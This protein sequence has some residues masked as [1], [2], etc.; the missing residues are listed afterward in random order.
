[1]RGARGEPDRPLVDGERGARGQHALRRR[2]SQ[3]GADRPRAGRADRDRLQRRARALSSARGEGIGTRAVHLRVRGRDD[4]RLVARRSA[5]LVD[6]RRHHRRRGRPRRCVPRPRSRHASGG[7]AR[8]YATDFH[9]AR[10]AMFDERWHR[11]TRRGAFVDRAI[12]AWYAPFGIQAAGSSIFVSYAWRAPVNGND[13]PTGGYV[14]EFDLDGKLVARVAHMGPLDEPWG[15]ALPRRVRAAGRRARGR[16]LRQRPSRRLRARRCRLRSPACS[17]VATGSRLRFPASGVSPSGTATWPALERRSSSRQG[18]TRGAA[19][20]SSACTACSA[21]LRRPAETAFPPRQTGSCSSVG[22]RIDRARRALHVTRVA[23]KSGIRNVL[24]EIGV[25]GTRDATPEGA[26][27]FR[28]ALEELGTTYVKLGQLLSSR[29]DLLPDIYI[30]ELSQLVD[31]VPPVPFA[32]IEGVI[33]ADLGDDVFTT[34]D[35]SPLAAASVAQTHRALLK[36]GRE[37]VVKVRRPG[38][39][40]Q[41]DLDLSVLRSTAAFLAGTPRR[42][43]FCRWKRSP[44]SSRCT[45]G[46]SST[47]SGGAQHGADR[48]PPRGLPAGDRSGGDPPARDRARARP[49]V[50]RGREGRGGARA[51]AGCRARARAGVLRCVRLPGRRR[52]GL[53]RRSAR[54]EHPS[55]AHGRL[56]LL[57]FGLL[58]RIHTTRGAGFS[59]LLL[60]IAQNRADDVADL[61]SASRS[62]TLNLGSTRVRPRR[63]TQAA[64][65]SLAP[66]V[67]DPERASR[68]PT[69]SGSRLQHKR[70]TYRQRS[71]SSAKRWR[72][73]TRS[74]ASS[75]PTSIRSH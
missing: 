28:R 6:D 24:A 48:R 44:T 35:P 1:M 65:L 52:R 33:L 60:A 53:P 15:M 67:G 74:R 54:R 31:T 43:S 63:A 69:C 72:R 8:L 39:V 70:P 12:P 13:A 41:V 73:P 50:H 18:P 51:R 5:R 57:D 27:S 71:H 56:A 45:C 20:P 66:L 9:N 46:R 2:R 55:D 30:E 49:R 17:T 34:I 19:P 26:R 29:P 58:G 22:A 40:E 36:T 3:A 11:V 10:I 68:S 42:R 75:I 14:D 21:R 4:P 61:I 62:P 38:V 64:A 32:D 37:V 23:Q 47:S 59:L 7:H 16:Q 25:R